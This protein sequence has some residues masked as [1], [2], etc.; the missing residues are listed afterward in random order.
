MTSV[1]ILY[2]PCEDGDGE[3]SS[4]PVAMQS[5]PTTDPYAHRAVNG[6]LLSLDRQWSAAFENVTGPLDSS[7]APLERRGSL[8][9]LYRE[10][11]DLG[12]EPDARGYYGCFRVNCRGDDG[13]LAE[14][15]RPP[16][17][18]F[19]HYG[20]DRRCRRMTRVAQIWENV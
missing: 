6:E 17:S 13:K 20:C 5:P 19:R 12:L 10:L 8:W 9:D 16:L 14:R 15:P 7:L 11:S 18:S 3:S 1:K 2:P 4:V